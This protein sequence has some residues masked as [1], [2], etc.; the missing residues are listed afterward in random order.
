M[1][2]D[3]DEPGIDIMSVIYAHD[4]PH[5]FPKEVMEQANKIPLHVLPEEKKG[6]VDITDQPLVTIDAIE[7]KT[8]MMRW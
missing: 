7:S 4:V 1:I 3:K 6:R 5:E 8:W 2:G